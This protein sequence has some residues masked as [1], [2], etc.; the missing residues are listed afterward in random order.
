MRFFDVQ[1]IEINAPRAHV[2]EF[3]RE[4]AHLTQWA[5]T[6]S[7]VHDC[8]SYWKPRRVPSTCPSKSR[9]LSSQN[10]P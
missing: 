7:L 5:E 8:R 10:H 4:P 9:T 1:G 6:F 2:F 3:V